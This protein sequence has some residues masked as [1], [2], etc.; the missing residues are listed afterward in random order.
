M[1]WIEAAFVRGGTSKG[2]FFA[3]DWLPEDESDRNRVFAEALGSP[4]RF[5]RQLD[6][7][8]GGISS[9]SKVMVVSRS[10]R[11]GVDLDYTFGQVAVDT[12]ETDYAGNCG[13]LSSGVVPFALEAGLVK[14][15][16][17][18][19]EFTLYNTNTAKIV[20]VVLTVIEGRA[21][22]GGELSL[23][24]VHGTAAPIELSYPDP[25]GS[26][27]AGLL[28]TGNP[29]DTLRVEGRD[30][31]VTLVDA[32]LPT[33][34]IEASRLGL[35]GTESPEQIDANK[36]VMELLEQIRR[37]GAAAMGLCATPEEAA[38]VMPKIVL[39][40]APAPA[41]LLDGTLS[42]AAESDLVIRVISMGQTHKAVPGTGA[43][44]LAAA[45]QVPGSIPAA[46]AGARQGEVIRLGTPSGSVSAAAHFDNAGKLAHTSL[47]RT[48]RV[49]MKGFVQLPR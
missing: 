18:R 43:M 30:Y 40:S 2:L 28:P 46:L 4:D 15:R 24:G 1:Q 12:G 37:A 39:A 26:R 10:Q 7:L 27:S 47:L 14:A 29:V 20:R 41:T 22:V 5:G 3:Q 36:P 49:L 19:R 44:C 11:E 21:A 35:E 25:A 23:P 33:V 34:V 48:A 42:D 45:A 13:N 6:G 16:D 38:L 32:A 31:P 17:G 9:L 8:G